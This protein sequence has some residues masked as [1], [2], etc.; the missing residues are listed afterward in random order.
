ML[1]EKLGFDEASALVREATHPIGYNVGKN[2]K[3]KFGLD[4]SPGDMYVVHFISPYFM[5]IGT[6]P[7]QVLE[8]VVIYKHPT[9]PFGETAQL[10]MD[11]LNIKDARRRA[12]AKFIICEGCKGYASGLTHAIAENWE[13]FVPKRM[14]AGDP[15][16][17]F[18]ISKT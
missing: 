2:I 8:D 18:M 3:E 15:H 12:D 6:D 11:C 4:G 17:L 1:D 9:C 5:K 13:T 10:V 14:A 16:C 7:V